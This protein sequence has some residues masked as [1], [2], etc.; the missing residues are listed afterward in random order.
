M[1]TEEGELCTGA[2]SG[3]A[4]WTAA[5]VFFGAVILLWGGAVWAADKDRTVD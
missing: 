4:G 2:S 1:G 5:F 3:E